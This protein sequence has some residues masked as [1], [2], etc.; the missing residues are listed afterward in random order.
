MKVFIYILKH[1]ETNAVRYVGKTNNIKNRWFNHLSKAKTKKAHVYSWIKSLLKRGI[2]PI[3]EVI[4]ECTIDNWETREK[5]WISYYKESGCKLCN[6]TTGGE[7][8]LGGY[9][10]IEDKVSKVKAAV[11][12]LKSGRS[13]TECEKLCG[14]YKGFLT[15]ARA[16]KIP[17]LIPFKIEIPKPVYT[18]HIEKLKAH[19]FKKGRANP[20][21]GIPTSLW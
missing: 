13:Q 19:A 10:D 3:M 11:G 12:L 2:S 5:Y 16:G 17:Y 14:L 9:V 15:Q 7:T 18:G 20:H 21:K 6:M 1:P 4:E 8:G